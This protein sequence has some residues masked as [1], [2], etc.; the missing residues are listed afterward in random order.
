MQPVPI[1]SLRNLGPKSSGWL[2]QVG[3]ETIEDLE[4]VGPTFAFC[5]VREQMPRV[6]LNL[7]WA[8]A[9]GLQG[10]DWRELDLETKARLREEID[11]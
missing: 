5:R 7:L 1:E 4:D 8:L 9:A 11:A 2:R 10:N 3:I 6:S